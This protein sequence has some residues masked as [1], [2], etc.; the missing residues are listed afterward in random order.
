M[1]LQG[2]TALIT[3]GTSGIGLATAQ[4]LQ[5]EGARVAVTGRS[6]ENLAC[7]REILGPDAL[8]IE[9]DCGNLAAI[10]HL[11][12]A[13]GAAFRQLDILVLNAGIASP[14]P[15][16]AVSEEA[17][18]AM[19]ST[20]FKG[21]FFTLQRALPLL[22]EGSSVVVT[23]S[24]TN[25]LGTPNFSIYGACKAAL[26]SMVSSLALELIPR[27]I[28]VNAV[29]PGPIATPM[30]DRFGLPTEVSQAI[31][32]EIQRKSP[33]QRFGQPTELAR[34]ILFLASD[35]SAYVV[36]EEIVVDG[37]MSLL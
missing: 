7:A 25:R 16:E 2:K 15:L 22:H 9:S 27:K 33:I 13:V 30:F 28:R 12:E 17:F 32:Q 1:K 10:D 14:A 24:I 36:G 37:G 34:V 3:G 31:Q 11:I 26:R 6:A 35:D 21:V 4:L 20:N 29:S 23:T 5:Q 19:V 18:D 8:V